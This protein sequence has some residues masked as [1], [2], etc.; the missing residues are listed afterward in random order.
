MQTDYAT[1]PTTRNTFRA[2]IRWTDSTESISPEPPRELPR[3]KRE[4]AWLHH[5]AALQQTFNELDIPDSLQEFY[6]AVLIASKFWEITDEEMA[7]ED[8]GWVELLDWELAA[9]IN[10]NYEDRQRVINRL[11]DKRAIIE[12]MQA[13]PD[14]PI[15]LQ[16][17]RVFDQETKRNRIFY[18]SPLGQIVRKVVAMRPIGSKP[19]KLQA[20]V[21]MQVYEF[22]KAQDVSGKKPPRKRTNSLKSKIKTGF[23]GLE[24]ALIEDESRPNQ[25]PQAAAV[26][27]EVYGELRTAAE[28]AGDRKKVQRLDRIL[29]ILS[30]LGDTTRGETHHPPQPERSEEQTLAD[31]SLSYTVGYDLGDPT[32]GPVPAR[33]MASAPPDPAP[34]AKPDSRPP[35]IVGQTRDEFIATQCAPAPNDWRDLPATTSQLALIRKAGLSYQ[36]SITRAD[37]SAAIKALL[38]SGALSD[39]LALAELE[40]FDP[41]GGR[42]PGD[43]RRWACPLCHGNRRMDADHRCFTANV[44][45][46]AY[47]CWR[48][49]ARGKLREFSHAVAT[50]QPR[51]FPAP[52]PQ[53]S[54]HEGLTNKQRARIEGAALIEGT[55]GAAY[56]EQRG[57]PSAAAAAAGVRFGRWWKRDE[58]ADQPEAFNAVI[59][60]IQNQSGELVAAQARAIEDNTKRTCGRKSEGVFLATPGALDAPR[61]YVAEAPLDALALAACGLNAVALCG[62]SW[63]A[64]LPAALAGRAVVVAFDVDE[65][66]DEAAVKL[67]GEL[68]E[69]SDVARIRPMRGKDWAE[70]IERDGIDS[71]AA[72]IAFELGEGESDEMHDCAF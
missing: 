68:A 33:E 27:A 49:D 50:I 56:I 46:G 14:A 23:T 44:S 1:T 8:G 48:C 19:D 57:I 63:P 3:S 64:W 31:R 22:L 58:E 55:A 29:Q 15:T 7:S 6:R 43:E 4:R 37:A 36:P 25:S 38:E 10:A 11:R 66:G 39:W 67:A 5:D 59:F 69:Q 51:N 40:R 9:A 54:D 65:A 52:N 17:N 13:S 32:P 41:R 62:T 2:P 28:K 45:T 71:T 70:V 72:Q 61:V 47:R 35:V 42:E 53:K 24:A 34:A 12:E 60:P 16:I 21:K 26:I 18:K 30:S 20:A